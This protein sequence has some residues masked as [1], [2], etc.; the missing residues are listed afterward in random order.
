MRTDKRTVDD[1]LNEQSLDEAAVKTWSIYAGPGA[2]ADDVVKGLKSKGLKARVLNNVRG[3]AALG[4][5]NVVITVDATGK[6]ATL[7][8][9]IQTL[10][11]VFDLD[12]E[13][14]ESIRRINRLTE[15]TD[16][17]TRPSTLDRQTLAL[18]EALLDGTPAQ[19][20]LAYQPQNLGFLEEQKGNRT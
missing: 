4:V 13:Q 9:L 14:R 6:A 15:T 20:T 11:A 3:A 12:D 19:R 7:D 2:E 5:M 17:L 10:E 18:G 1:L 8:G 16:R